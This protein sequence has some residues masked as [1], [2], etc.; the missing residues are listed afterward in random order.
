[1]RL[2]KVKEVDAGQT[3][4]GYRFRITGVGLKNPKWLRFHPVSL[5]LAA[6]FLLLITN[7]ESFSMLARDDI[8]T[9]AK[10]FKAKHGVMDEQDENVVATL[11]LMTAHDMDLHAAQDHTSRSGNDHG[12]DAWQYDPLSN[13]LTL[14]QSKLTTS[15][16]MALKGVGRDRSS[17]GA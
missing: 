15:K 5:S 6:G 17:A 11:Y 8:V 3:E 9:R 13:T 2:R 1:M 10:E 7:R 12:I 16:A 4:R 14:Y